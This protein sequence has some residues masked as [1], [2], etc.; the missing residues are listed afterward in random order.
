MRRLAH[1]MESRGAPPLRAPGGGRDPGTDLGRPAAVAEDAP[2]RRRS[3]RTR[4]NRGGPAPSPAGA[5]FIAPAVPAARTRRARR[6]AGA[7]RG[8]VRRLAH[9][10]ES[11]GQVGDGAAAG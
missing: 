6:S 8:S 4:W 3:P 11:T 10:R 1:A 9:A 5:R 2:S 7:V